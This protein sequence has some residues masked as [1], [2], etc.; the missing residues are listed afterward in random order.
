MQSRDTSTKFEAPAE[1][2][3]DK[4]KTYRTPNDADTQPLKERSDGIHD[5]F[6]LEGEDAGTPRNSEPVGRC[7]TISML[8]QL[9]ICNE[10]QYV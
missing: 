10:L 8:L 7:W 4:M 5:K 6:K 3:E 9:A 2:V 1:S